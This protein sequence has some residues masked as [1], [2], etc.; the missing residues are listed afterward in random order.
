MNKM[1]LG[2]Y[3]PGTSFMHRLDPRLKLI[4]NVYIIGLIFLAHSLSDY[5]LLTVILVAG[6]RASAVSLTYFIKGLKPMLV[7]ILLTVALQLVMS[8]GGQVYWQWGPF[9]LAQG[10]IVNATIVAFRFTM[11][12]FMSTLLTLT[13]SPLSIADGISSLLQP[14]RWVK[15][16]VEEV[17]LMISIALRF[18]PKLLDEAT[19]ITNAQRSRGVDFNDPN[20]IKRV[21]AYIPLLVPLLINSLTIA[22]DLSLAMTSRGYRHDQ[23]RSHFRQL[24]WRPQDTIVAVVSIILGIIMGLY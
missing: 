12:I 11:I 5:L 19:K 16:P 23:P 14:L 13:T 22:D 4:V 15:F 6:I 18:I 7:L 20:L 21:Q 24:K 1:I 3:L 10:G 8:P 9:I 2:R 17:A